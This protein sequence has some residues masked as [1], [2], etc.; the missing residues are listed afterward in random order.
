MGYKNFY[1]YANI[2]LFA[3]NYFLPNRNRNSKFYLRFSL[4]TSNANLS[5]C[6]LSHVAKLK[7]YI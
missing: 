1:M 6:G 2:Q 4:F 3:F 7:F 5:W